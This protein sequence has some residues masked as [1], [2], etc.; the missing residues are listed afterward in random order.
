MDRG[1]LL[2]GTGTVAQ[3]RF[4]AG[5]LEKRVKLHLAGGDGDR[6]WAGGQMIDALGEEVA[7]ALPL[8]FGLD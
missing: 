8:P 1:P 5:L 6:S 7:R 2:S 3:R 4:A